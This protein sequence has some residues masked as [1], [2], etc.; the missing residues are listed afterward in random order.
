[1]TTLE[2]SARDL[3]ERMGVEGAQ[4]F[5]AGEL[6]ELA[7]LIAESRSA[8][9]S[10]DPFGSPTAGAWR[11]GR[12]HGLVNL[13]V[14]TVHQ[15]AAREVSPEEAHRVIERVALP[16]L[17]RPEAGHDW[18]PV[19]RERLAELLKLI[20]PQPTVVG[21]KTMMFRNPMAAEVLTQLSAEVRAMVEEARQ[22]EEAKA[23][24]MRR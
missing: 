8:A 10:H 23:A 24:E 1:M 19:R 20:D 5:S 18:M 13:L 11:Q 21:E 17:E 16:L 12:I 2:Q 3:L 9:Q 22:Q 4:N 15:L 6:V 14:A 7:N